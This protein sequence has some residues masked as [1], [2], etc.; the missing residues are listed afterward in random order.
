MGAKSEAGN[1]HLLVIVDRA[2]KFLFA[3]RLPNKTAENMDKKHLKLLLTFGIPLSLPSNPGTEFSVEVV[4][5]LCT[6][7]NVTIDYGPSDHPRAQGAVERL[8]AWIHKTLVEPWKNWS[9]RWDEHPIHACQAK[10][11]PSSY[12]SVVTA[13]P[14]WMLPHQ[15]PTTTAWADYITSS[16][17]RAKTF[18]KYRKSAKTC[19]AETAPTRAPLPGPE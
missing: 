15:G 1:K 18:V 7:L 17:T 10:P 5:H 12:Y 8:G 16:L 4:Q 11:P 3:Y 13:A 9:R 6:W 19:R 2:S 14:K